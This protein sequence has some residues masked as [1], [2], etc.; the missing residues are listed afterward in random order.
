MFLPQKSMQFQ[1]KI[2]FISG[3]HIS[4]KFKYQYYE[5]IGKKPRERSIL[6][7]T[8]IHLSL[9]REEQLLKIIGNCPRSLSSTV[10][11]PGVKKRQPRKL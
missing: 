8:F 1:V 3:A 10:Y 2:D 11:T 4:A 9:G 7:N 5:N 6:S